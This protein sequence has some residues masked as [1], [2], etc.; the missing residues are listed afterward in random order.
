MNRSRGRRA[1]CVAAAIGRAAPSALALRS[2]R[3][4]ASSSRMVVAS[5]NGRRPDERLL[6]RRDADLGLIGQPLARDAPARQLLAHE[7][8]H[9][10]AL[11]VGEL[12]LGCGRHEA[13]R[14]VSPHIPSHIRTR[15]PPARRSLAAPCRTSAN[16]TLAVREPARARRMHDEA[17]P[18]GAT[19]MSTR[20]QSIAASAPTLSRM[21]LRRVQRLAAGAPHILA[22]HCDG[23]CG[24]FCHGRTRASAPP[25]RPRPCRCL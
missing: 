22:P 7:R 9:R 13:H 18:K 1:R 2:G 4:S 17:S 25:Q 24:Y 14:H 19:G 11:L 6:Q 16:M 15:L 20:G 5:V 23:N 10:A 12:P 21:P 8:R 3:P